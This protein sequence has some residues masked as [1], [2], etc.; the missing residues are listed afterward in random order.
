MRMARL[1]LDTRLDA[2][3]ADF[4]AIIRPSAEVLVSLVNELLKAFHRSQ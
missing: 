3:Q 1:L 4:A 2:E